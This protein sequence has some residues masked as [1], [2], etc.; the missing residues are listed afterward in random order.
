MGP[1]GRKKCLHR[2][3]MTISL[4]RKDDVD[5]RKH[6]EHGWFRRPQLPLQDANAS[7]ETRRLQQN[8]K[9]HCCK[10]ERGKSSSGPSHRILAYLP[11]SKPQC[12]FKSREGWRED[13]RSWTS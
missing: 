12:C 5:L 1:R 9:N 2:R 10:S 4:Q 11:W 13:V 6:S 3:C 7:R 8:E